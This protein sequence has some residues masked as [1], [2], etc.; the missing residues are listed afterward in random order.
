MLD[1][2][3]LRTFLTAANVGSFTGAAKQ[4]FMTHSAVSQQMAILE[5]EVGIPLIE[6]TARGIELTDAGRILADRCTMLFGVLATIESELKDLRS[7]NSCI[8][9]GAF[10]TASADLIPWVLQEFTRRHP[11]VGIEFLPIH[12]G[13]ISD[14]LRD[15]SIHAGLAWEYDVVPRALGHDIEAVHLLD[16]PLDLLVPTAHPLAGAKSLTLAA[17][18]GERWILR[19]HKP[20]FDRAFANMCRTAGFEPE[21]IF[22]TDDYQAI[23]GFVGAGLG[24]SLVPRMSLQV[25][26]PSVTAVPVQEPTL[27]RRILM[28][29][30]A[31]VSL[32]DPVLKLL[33]VLRAA[34]DRFGSDS[35]D[36]VDHTQLRLVPTEPPPDEPPMVPAAPTTLVM[37]PRTSGNR[38]KGI[39]SR[40]PQWRQG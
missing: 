22:T 3:R 25:R 18:A 12:V 21:V 39:I 27:H 19:T 4:L 33:D 30:L 38:S 40:P 24:V 28:L 26:H 35:L 11:S 17:M 34:A 37:K 15:G 9:F 13:D 36:G 23:H 2:R 7:M 29:T 14:R 5:R 10:P 32:T 20:P 16:E 8:R 31:H 6:R 1:V